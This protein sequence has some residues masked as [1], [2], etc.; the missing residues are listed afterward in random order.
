MILC[1][2]IYL[3]SLYFVIY[4]TSLYLTVLLILA[5][6]HETSGWY[7]DRFVSRRF[8]SVPVDQIPPWFKR[9]ALSFNR[10]TYLTSGVFRNFSVCTSLDLS[11]NC[12]SLI[13]PGAFTGLITLT[14]LHLDA[15]NIQSSEL[16]KVYLLVL[17]F[18]SATKKFPAL[19][20]APSEDWIV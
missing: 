20:K 14:A 19:K 12:I 3:T 4:I 5:T 10:I 16:S 2:V 15:N 6:V 18:N 11:F 1:S 9:V 17:T 7:M 8:T 13:E